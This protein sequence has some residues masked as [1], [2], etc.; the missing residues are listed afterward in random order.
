MV[1]GE[2]E[3]VEVVASCRQVSPG[4]FAWLAWEHTE[5]AWECGPRESEESCQTGR[6]RLVVHGEA[7]EHT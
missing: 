6:S 5:Q 7:G 3:E 4:M 1:V 2:V